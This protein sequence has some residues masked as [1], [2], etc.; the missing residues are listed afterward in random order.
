[1]EIPSGLKAA[2]KVKNVLDDIDRYVDYQKKSKGEY[3]KTCS[4]FPE[5]YSA[6]L[7]YCNDFCTKN[8]LSIYAKVEPMTRRGVRILKYGS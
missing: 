4:L 1:M 6:L 5:E 7:N 2:Q 8:G 3:P